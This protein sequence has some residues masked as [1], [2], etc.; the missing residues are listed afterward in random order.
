MI[1]TILVL[2]LLL[3]PQVR[4]VTTLL[5]PAIGGSWMVSRVTR[6]TNLLLTVVLLSKDNQRGLDNTTTKT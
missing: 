5:L 2:A 4:T 1:S 6:T 3:D